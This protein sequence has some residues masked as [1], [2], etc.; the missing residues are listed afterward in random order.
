MRYAGSHKREASPMAVNAD[1]ERVPIGLG[2]IMVQVPIAE[3][4]VI[5]DIDSL[6]FGEL[7]PIKLHQSLQHRLVT[8]G[9]P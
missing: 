1:E 6:C 8:E 2:P 4:P 5:I 7:V 3:E 9:R